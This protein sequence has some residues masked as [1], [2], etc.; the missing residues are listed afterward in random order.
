M[1]GSF[2]R[3]AVRRGAGGCALL[4][5]I[6]GA[7]A[8]I[9]ATAGNAAGSLDPLDPLSRKAAVVP[10]APASVLIAATRADQ[11]VIVAGENGIVLF[12]DDAAAHWQQAAV[13]VSVTLTAMSFADAER[14]WA[15]GHSGVVLA[16]TDGGRTWTRQLDGRAIAGLP[17]EAAA[18]ADDGDPPPLPNAGDPLLDVLFLDANEG[19]A[20]GAFGLFL[21]TADGGAHWTRASARL[22]N[23]DGNH[24]YGIRLIGDRLYVVG[25]RGAVFVSSDRGAHFEALKTPYEG[26]FFGLTGNADGAVVVFGLQGR[27][28]VSTD[29]G[30]HWNDVGGDGS[31]AW[32]GGAT[33]DDGRMVLVGQAGDVRLQQAAGGRF[34]RWSGKQPPLSAVAAG[35]DGRLVAVGPRGVH[36]IETAAATQGSEQP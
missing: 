7:G 19:F 26:S 35:P 16:T 14:G 27:A 12:S 25:E 33:L 10:N 3:T 13:P 5:L 20:I 6:A 4:A 18:G 2:L 34:D 21:H 36:V 24:L 11:R 15:V 1:N 23:P 8:A 29:H 32:T 17:E 28:F 9:Q 22:P 31:S 30:A